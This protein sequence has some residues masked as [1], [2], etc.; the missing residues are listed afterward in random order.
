MKELVLGGE[1]DDRRAAPLVVGLVAQ[2]GLGGGVERVA[3]KMQGCSGALP[4]HGAPA[5]R[6]HHRVAGIELQ[7]VRVL[8]VAHPAPQLVAPAAL[9]AGCRGAQATRE[10]QVT[11]SPAAGAEVLVEAQQHRFPREGE[12]DVAGVGCSVKVVVVAPRDIELQAVLPGVGAPA[13]LTLEEGRAQRRG[14]VGAREQRLVELQC[15]EQL[16]CGKEDA[17]VVD[18]GGAVVGV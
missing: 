16:A 10:A 14:Q 1:V 6:V 18:L 11:V 12:G 2:A 7:Q 4:L 8:V 15:R 5:G 17:G 9:T 3:A 13:G